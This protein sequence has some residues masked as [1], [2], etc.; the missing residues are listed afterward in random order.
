MAACCS[1]RCFRSAWR[2]R[3]TALH[4][5]SS[6]VEAAQQTDSETCLWLVVGDSA[7]LMCEKYQRKKLIGLPA[8]ES[9]DKASVCVDGCAA[10]DADGEQEFDR[11]GS[12]AE[13]EVIEAYRISPRSPWARLNPHDATRLLHHSDSST[14]YF[15]DDAEQADIYLRV[16]GTDGDVLPF[17]GRCRTNG[18]L[19]FVRPA[20]RPVMRRQP[21]PLAPRAPIDSLKRLKT[22]EGRKVEAAPPLRALEQTLSDDVIARLV[23]HGYAI[24]DDALPAALCR[25]LRAEM[26]ALESNGQM[27][28][29]K[30]YGTDD[31]GAPHP[32]INETQLDFKE[33]RKH[34]PTF[35][36]ME[37]DPSLVERLR[38]VPG[39]EKLASQHVR[40]QINEGHGGCYTMHTDSGTGPMGPG[41]TLCL[42]AL[43]YLNEEW[44]PADGGELR[45]FPYPHAAHVIAPVMGR[46]VLFEPRMVHDVL[47][48]H[49]KRFCFTLWCSQKTSTLSGSGGGASNQI[50]HATLQKA[51]LSVRLAQGAQICEGW[52][53][54]EKHFIA[55]G[56]AA[57]L[58]AGARKA[59]PLASSGAEA[60][61]LTT[62][63]SVAQPPPPLPPVL[64]P[65]FLP[66]MRMMLVRIV[67]KADEIA[68]V[69][70]SHAG[71][72]K[73]REM[74][75]GITQHHATIEQ[76][77]P[78]WLLDLLRML[79]EATGDGE[80]SE[81]DEQDD[82]VHVRLA[83]LRAH[84]HR[85]APW[86]IV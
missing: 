77:N 44:E 10:S 2:R 61:T 17:G 11:I 37:H 52:R 85:L 15:D 62:A 7:P 58:K 74:V 34:A 60:P 66:E 33:V 86:W 28:N 12:A 71:T 38:G 20:L 40:I 23:E 57:N 41:Q 16:D 82:R 79:P 70:Q 42:T 59:L 76:Q 3:K 35:A 4:I 50:D 39:L 9:R 54:R 48:N 6:H 68:Q 29:S 25:K 27:W 19:W 45:V 31:D 67:H 51:E 22:M 72:D 24:V 73:A 47:P 21:P 18:E 26:Q 65:L 75:A 43:I 36:R 49:K 1:R 80:V 69:A 8:G 13:G 53:R 78:K 30:S 83:E 63:L 84:M 64:R 55:Y 5:V 14:D 46:L 81:A 56:A 32:H